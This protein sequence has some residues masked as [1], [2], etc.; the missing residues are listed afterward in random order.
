MHVHA[1]AAA[2]I[3]IEYGLHTP[4]QGAAPAGCGLGDWSCLTAA[5]GLFRVGYPASFSLRRCRLLVRQVRW[6]CWQWQG[7]FA[8]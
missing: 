5:G 7:G 6:C 3:A 4:G 1:P 2:R 8:L